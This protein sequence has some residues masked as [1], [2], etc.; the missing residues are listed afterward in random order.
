MSRAKYLL[1]E[2]LEDELKNREIDRRQFS[3]KFPERHD[4]RA[5]LLDGRDVRQLVHGHRRNEGRQAL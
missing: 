2:M 3:N 4:S 1:D 5:A